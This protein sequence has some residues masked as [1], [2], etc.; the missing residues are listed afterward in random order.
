MH[1]YVATKGIKHDVDQFITEL[2]G[3]YL[4]FKWREKDTDPFLDAQ[5]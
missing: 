3:K 1:L 5:L 4:P 2:Q